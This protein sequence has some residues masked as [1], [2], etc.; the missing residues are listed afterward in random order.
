[1]LCVGNFPQVVL[2]E[3]FLGSNAKVNIILQLFPIQFSRD[4][5]A[6]SLCDLAEGLTALFDFVNVLRNA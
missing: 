2:L 4:S 3:P 6:I 5:A 1:M